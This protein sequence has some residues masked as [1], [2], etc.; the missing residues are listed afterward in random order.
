[1]AKKRTARTQRVKSRATSAGKTARKVTAARVSRSAGASKKI[2][3]RTRTIRRQAKSANIGARTPKRTLRPSRARAVAP[4]RTTTSLSRSRRRTAE[5]R[6]RS[7]AA[8][9]GW[10]TRR[11]NEKREARRRAAETRKRADRD[12]SR[13]RAKRTGGVTKRT[14]ARAEFIGAANYRASRRGNS[15]SIQISAVGPADASASDAEEAIQEKIATGSAPKGWS[16]RLIDWKDP[17]AWKKMRKPL[18]QATI[19][20][21]ES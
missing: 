11:A 15:V 6:A 20:V 14:R 21:T 4:K 8:A 7:T 3:T 9:K 2:K 19:D 5:S 18:E 12:R 1:M 17:R 16:I 13:K 10:I